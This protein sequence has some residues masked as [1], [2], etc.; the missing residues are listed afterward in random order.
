MTKVNEIW[1]DVSGAEYFYQVSSLGRIK[2][3]SRRDARGW[4]IKERILK[5]ECRNNDGYVCVNL[6]CIGG[7]FRLHRIIAKAFI[8]NPEN[9]PYIN[10]INGIK[11][12]NRIENLEW[13]TAKE[14]IQH[15]YLLGLKDNLGEKGAKSKLKNNQVVE[16]FSSKERHVDIACKYGI[17]V[18]TVGDIKNRRTWKKITQE[19][20]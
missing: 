4:R 10:H 11:H 19:L 12:D 6:H 20:A 7:V 5:T 17:C 16:I 15:A 2:S 18:D 8:P 3:K 9:K 13:C 14:N 1:K